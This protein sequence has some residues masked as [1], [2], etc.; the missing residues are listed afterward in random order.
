MHLIKL[1]QALQESKVSHIKIMCVFLNLFLKSAV[2]SV[3]EKVSG[4]MHLNSIMQVGKYTVKYWSRCLV[5][6]VE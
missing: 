3:V 1:I 5:T 4:M 2:K 6:L